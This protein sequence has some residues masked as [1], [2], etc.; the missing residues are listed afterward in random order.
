[1]AAAAGAALWGVMG[2]CWGRTWL[3]AVEGGV[4]DEAVSGVV[5]RGST[6]GKVAGGVNA[7]RSN[8]NDGG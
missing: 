8:L 5:I 1:M 4:E 2:G 6:G 3:D 7:K